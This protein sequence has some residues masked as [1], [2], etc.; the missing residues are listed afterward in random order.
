MWFVPC[1][2]WQPLQSPTGRPPSA[3][4]DAAIRGV[5]LKVTFGQGGVGQYN[6]RLK[7]WAA[8]AY[9]RFFAHNAS[10]QPLMVVVLNKSDLDGDPVAQAAEPA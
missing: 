1:G 5:S 4:G 3:G 9:L 7:D 10:D 6:P 2:S 8:F